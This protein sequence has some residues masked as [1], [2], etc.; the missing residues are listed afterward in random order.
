[1]TGFDAA[2]AF[3][4]MHEGSGCWQ[5]A[6][7]DA[8]TCWGIYLKANPDLKA[9]WPLSKF[10]ATEVARERYWDAI[11]A[12]D[13]EPALAMMAFDAAFNMG[14]STAKRFL[15]RTRD[16]AEYAA[17]RLKAYAEMPGWAVNGKGWVR[18]V[19]DCLKEAVEIEKLG[20]VLP[21]YSRGE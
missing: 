18:R 13:L 7:E 17:L 6:G 20:R 16:I 10:R 14:T 12:D 15:G 5:G 19:A 4:L 21:L 8:Q 3:V 1:M 9:E 2:W 11:G